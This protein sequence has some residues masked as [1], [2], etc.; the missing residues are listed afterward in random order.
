MDIDG[1]VVDRIEG[2][3]RVTVNILLIVVLAILLMWVARR[4]INRFIESTKSTSAVADRVGDYATRL[5]TIARVIHRAIEGVIVIFA[6]IAIMSEF[7]VD[8]T[9]LLA[10]AGIAGIAL[11]FGAQ[12]LVRDFL[13][14]IL[15]V[16]EDQFRVGDVVTIGEVTGTVEELNLRCTLMRDVD[17][18]MHIIPNGEIR[19]ATNHG[20]GYSNVHMEVRV[21]YDTDLEKVTTV[22]DRVG[23]EMMNDPEW[24]PRLR[25]A[26]HFFRVQ[27]FDGLAMVV[28][29]RAET[30][31]LT[32]WAISGELRRRLKMAFDAEGIRI[33]VP[34]QVFQELRSEEKQQPL[35]AQPE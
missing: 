21:P 31:P 25:S 20:W 32:Q 19:L 9:A 13:T 10:S 26:P 24:G 33:A 34:Q 18:S 35:V 14:G 11:S 6:G 1:E 27:D 7:G 4:L 22:I 30:E 23:Q 15:I 8:T 28:I 17:G 3:G 12:S 16:V 29:V 5:E 2:A